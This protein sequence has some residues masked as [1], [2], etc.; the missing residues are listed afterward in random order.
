MDAVT[1]ILR[2]MQLTSAVVSRGTFG[3]PW[4]VRTEGGTGAIFH[5][6]S[7]GS[8]WLVDVPSGDRFEL[9]EGEI[10]L[11]RRGRAH[12]VCD[13]PRTRPTVP[14]AAVAHASADPS[15]VRYGGPGDETRVLCGISKLD[16]SGGASLLDA[17]PP[18]VHVR[19]SSSDL[20]RWIDDTL[21]LVA[22]ELAS[23]VPGADAV[24]SRLL[25]LLFVQ[26]LRAAAAS[27]PKD[28]VGW[29]AAVHDDRI[30]KA[31]S[32][33]H[34]EPERAWSTEALARRSGMSRSAFFDRF[35]A[36]VGEPPARY[37]ARWRVVLAVDL[38]RKKPVDLAEL[39][40]RL[41]YKSEGA[42]SKAFKRYT[43]MTPRAMRSAFEAGAT[44]DAGSLH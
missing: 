36:L 12:V 10:A 31:L 38:V 6:V 3:R 7:R 33:I 29:L 17:L 35:T 9:R 4:S 8:C 22:A 18:V 23:G 13:D 32:A 25:D 21:A 34:V 24:V 28:A 11:V 26:I 15:A 40:A 14:I 37:L 39:A 43:G 44:F 30:G 16:L 2:S 19:R 5:A 20:V 1:E 41:G 27:L 42:F